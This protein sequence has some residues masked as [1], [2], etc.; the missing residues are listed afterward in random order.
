MPNDNEEGQGEQQEHKLVPA[1]TLN[2]HSDRN[3]D[4]TI[5]VHVE[6]YPI[7]LQEDWSSGIGGGLWSTGLALAHYCT[8]QHFI[9]QLQK[10]RQSSLT[11]RIL[12]LGSGNG[13]LSVCL[14]VA[15]KILTNCTVHVVATD[16]TEHLSLMKST[17]HLN[18]TCHTGRIDVR[19]YISVQEYVWGVTTKDTFITDGSTA[20]EDF[21]LIIGSD[22]AYRDELHDPLIDA[23][24][25]LCSPDTII[26]LGITMTD[27][28][29]IFFTKLLK[30]GFQY[31]KLS[32]SLLEPTFR[33][34]K[35]F[36]IF[37][38]RK[39]QESIENKYTD[40][41]I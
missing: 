38:I 35:Q 37:V 27:T 15:T 2:F 11:T 21:D 18:S 24:Q 25:Q 30:N 32:D 9:K 29:P 12:E 41:I 14:V 34:N 33:S 4:G 39:V 8:T 22:L 3:D 19:P 31:E 36:G 26:L 23:F 7:Y 5:N 10:R 20:A 16:T 28:K 13:F 6:E 40:N 1:A 17:I